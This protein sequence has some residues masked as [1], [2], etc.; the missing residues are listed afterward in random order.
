M[1]TYNKLREKLQNTDKFSNCQRRDRSPLIHEGFPGTFN[2]SFTEYEYLRKYGN[3]SEFDTDLVFSTIQSCIRPQDIT[4]NIANGKGIWKYLGVFE[5]AD[6][7]GQILLANRNEVNDVHLW[8]INQLGKFLRENGLDLKKIYPTYNAG[9]LVADIT[10]GKYVFDFQ[11]PEDLLSKQ[12]FID[13]DIPQENC[14][15]DKTRDTFLSLHLN[16]K[17]PWG[18]RNEINYNIGTLENPLL[19]DIGTL[20]RIC[21]FP[22]YSGNEEISKNIN[23]LIPINHT[24]SVSGFGLERLCVAINGLKSVDEVDYIKEFYDLFSQEAPGLS[25][26]Q[27]YKAG[28]VVRALHRIYSDLQSY[29]LNLSKCRKEK[30]KKFLQILRDNTGNLLND[31]ILD[32][33][34]ITNTDTQPW[35]ANLSQG[36][37]PTKQRILRYLEARKSK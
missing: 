17:S 33:L 21:W 31:K 27:R 14:I 29:D 12:G 34:L 7:G 24:L 4:E 36:I 20:E 35:H 13:I 26:E 19:L 28:E 23:G 18:Y 3:F 9:G 37:E 2:L 5:M 8:Q 1:I 6:W 30:V 15:S 22:T 10:Q 25:S 16:Q 32:S 11:V